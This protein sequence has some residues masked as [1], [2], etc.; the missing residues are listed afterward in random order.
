LKA[1]SVLLY[2]VFFQREYSAEEFIFPGVPFCDHPVL[3]LR[4]IWT[5]NNVVS[6]QTLL[7]FLC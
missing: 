4:G 6:M 2:T 7:G 3:F 1:I 5:R